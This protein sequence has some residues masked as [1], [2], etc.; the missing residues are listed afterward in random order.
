MFGRRPLSFKSSK[1]TA[2]KLAFHGRADNFVL[3][4]NLC[5]S[6]VS[7]KLNSFH[8]LHFEAG[9]ENTHEKVCVLMRINNENGNAKRKSAEE[10]K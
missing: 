1:S 8:R 3:S 5:S 10:S 9:I 2:R 7:L 4:I 6:Y